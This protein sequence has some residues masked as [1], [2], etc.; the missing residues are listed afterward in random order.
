MITLSFQVDPAYLAYYTIRNCE[1]SRFVNVD[2]ENNQKI[3]DFQ[4][5]A[6]FKDRQASQFIRFGPSDVNVLAS[7]SIVEIAQRAEKLI[8]SV[9]DDATF[10][11]L[12][13]ET[14]HSLELIRS[15]WER[16][17]LKTHDMISEMTG[18][19]LKGDFRVFLTHQALKQGYYQSE[20][21]AMFCAYRNS[22]PN[23]NTVYI[24]HELL[25]HFIPGSADLEHAVIQL[26]TD[27]ELRIRLNG[28]QYPPFEGHPYL[29]PLMELIVPHWRNYLNSK[30]RKIEK[31]ICEMAARQDVKHQLSK[32]HADNR[33]D[34]VD[35]L[36]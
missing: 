2:D 11:P 3:V 9:L 27:N 35:A 5:A 8:Q 29:K 31:F 33:D 16:N 12:L 30:N 17:C 36:R 28:G 23:Y 13:A 21:K 32:C 34:S 1:A 18:F 24:W 25:H 14:S 22:W 10:A 20:L 6:W 4:N 19:T 15:Q 7:P 26:I